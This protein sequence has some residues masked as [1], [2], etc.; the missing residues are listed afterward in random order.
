[1]FL[2]L[3]F[4]NNSVRQY[5]LFLL[6]IFLGFV[7]TEFVVIIS[8]HLINF[9][10]H[11][12]TKIDDILTSI[13][14][15]PYPLKII[16]VTLF[17]QIAISFLN[18]SIGLKNWINGIAYFTYVL[19]ISLF[20][21]KFIEGIIRE[22]VVVK[23]KQTKS[24]Y[25]DQLLP[26]MKSMIKIIIWIIAILV[27]L[28]KFGVNITALLGGLGIG[29]LAIAM[30]SKDFFENF[31]SGV[32]IF[33][34]KPFQIDDVVQTSDGL[35]V[36][37]EIGLR[38]TRVQTFEGTM[39]VIPNN[40]LSSNS[41]ENVSKRKMRKV[42]FSIGVTYDTSVTKLEQAKKIIKEIFK[43]NK[44]VSDEYYVAFESFGDFSLN[45]KIIYW[46]TTLDYGQY[47]LVKDAV[48]MS[49]KK[50]FEKAKIDMAFPT[51]TI[52]LKK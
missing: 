14:E 8:R 27:I 18:T 11:T 16:V 10:K 43:K 40:K 48:N 51:Q 7:A 41:V 17:V 12:K 2:D 6:F 21:I 9:A 50:E 33:F 47:L 22:Y 25:D 30:A 4:W 3:V 38:S 24:K 20:L 31:I 44:N 52:E 19:G 45:I 34:E 23:V 1:M 49:I 15:K 32:V 39:L 46:I 35:G 36:V 5:F 13:L 28:S 42:N 26:L 37:K 29:G